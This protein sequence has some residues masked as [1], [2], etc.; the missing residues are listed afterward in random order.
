MKLRIV[1]VGERIERDVLQ[2]SRAALAALQSEVQAAL[3]RGE[4]VTLTIE[5]EQ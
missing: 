2:R 1:L 4:K 5:R 3:D